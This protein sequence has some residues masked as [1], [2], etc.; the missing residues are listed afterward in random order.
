MLAVIALYSKTGGKNGK[1]S[2]V[3]ESLKISAISYM[4]VQVFEY[5]YARQFHCASRHCNLSNT[6][7]SNAPINQFSDAPRLQG[8]LSATGLYS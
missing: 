3:S 2:S 8:N 4:G 1:H 7:I 5:M 6:S